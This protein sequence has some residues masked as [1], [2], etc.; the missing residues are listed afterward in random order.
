MGETKIFSMNCQGL[1]NYR[2]RK[3]VL[4]YIRAR[5]Y[6]IIC[7][8]DIHVDKNTAQLMLNEWGYGGI[9]APHTTAAR[10]VAVMF[11]NNLEY[12]IHQSKLDPRGNFIV[13]SLQ[14]ENEML[15]LINLYGPNNDTPDFYSSLFA[16]IDFDSPVIICGDWNL[17]LDPKIDTQN[18]IRVN[19]P[20]AREKVLQIIEENNLCDPWR[21]QH[22]ETKGFTWRKKTP[23]KQA[24]LDFFLTTEDMMSYITD[25]KIMP[26][27]KT[28]HSAILITLKFSNGDRGK[29]Y[30]KFNNSFLK[31]T[32]FADNV[33]KTINSVLSQYAATPYKRETIETLPREE[34][35]FQIK[36]QLLLDVMLMEIRQQSIEYGAKKKKER[37]K[38]EK[39][40]ENNIA[41]AEEELNSDV[42]DATD[43]L[44]EKLENFKAELYQIRE[45]KL[46]GLI[47]RSKARWYNEGEKPTK[48]FCGLE[49]RNYTAKVIRELEI[50][51]KRITSQADIIN[52]QKTF[53]EKL[54]DEHNTDTERAKKVMTDMN[55]KKITPIQA[56][57]IEGQISYDELCQ[58]VRQMKNNKSPG[59]DGYSVEFFKFFWQDLGKLILRAINEAYTEGKFSITQRR[60]VITCLPKPNKDRRYL[61]NWRPITL[62]TVI[63]KM[64]S[65]CIANRLRQVLDTII[66]DDQSGFMKG[67]FI[68]DNIRVLYDIL[69]ETKI[70]NIPGLMISIDFEKAFDS[71]SSQFI[72]QAL[73]IFGFG[74][75]IQK[76]V[77]TLNNDITGCIIQNGFL[78]RSFPI[79]RGCRQG[80]PAAPYIFLISIQI[81]IDMIKNNASIRGIRLN[82]IEHKLSF[83]ADDG[84]IY[85][86]GEEASLR[87][88]MNT[89]N[90]F[91]QMSG[92]KVNTKKT[93]AIWIGKMRKN[94]D[95]I[96]RDL[97]L[98]WAEDSFTVLG[99]KFNAEL[100][101][102]TE[103]NLEEKINKIKCLLTQWKRRK[104]SLLG[105]ITVIKTLAVSQITHILT[106]LP[107]PTEY[108]MKEI[109]KL[110]YKFL[111]NNGPDKIKRNIIIQNYDKGG[112]KMIDIQSF[113]QH[114]K[115]TWIKRAITADHKWCT[116]S[117]S[118]LNTHDFLRFGANYM[119]CTKATRNPF[120]LDVFRAWETLTESNIIITMSAEELL[121][122]PIWYNTHFKNKHLCIQNWAKRGIIFIKDL[123]DENG[124][125]WKFEILKKQYDI[126][127]TILDYEQVKH[128]IPDIW[129]RKLRNT[130]NTTMMPAVPKHIKQIK[131]KNKKAA[132]NSIIER[133]INTQHSSMK[134]WDNVIH[135]EINWTQVY[136]NAITATQSTYL[137][138]FHYKAIYNVICTNI[139]LF[140]MKV[141]EDDTCSFCHK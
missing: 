67:R 113:V 126:R 69:Y 139:T 90:T 57:E 110:F 18:Y 81:L 74:E 72:Q 136:K 65:G 62:L 96:C 118:K 15:T 99:V 80:D 27:Y 45:E 37:N 133:K 48:Y 109:Q 10:G 82:S 25:S 105:K 6:N 70:Q 4:N 100:E 104:L 141:K 66:S 75:S 111:W 20:R 59:Q 39:E 85:L 130:G 79:K 19:N 86:D 125:F 40:L 47:T 5:D 121:S 129:T 56:R 89:L 84:L 122:E 98:T 21:V 140:R 34:I 17:A 114:L 108:T 119:K 31:D 58:T 124:N 115:L 76:W 73:Q 41:L 123:L 87:A 91:Y 83:Y 52:E 68:G 44:F 9:I 101:N 132:Y 53:Y 11:S 116:L 102:I 134:K 131:S 8:Q 135:E 28:D 3:D 107:N 30:W 78:S 138:S 35:H 117:F 24:R 42:S 38:K 127:G 103:I 54:Y 12:K 94:T 88:L 49:K 1:A 71:I 43:D 50:D 61:S 60:G 92:L 95:P 26:G 2:N 55:I 29:G 23:R 36:D 137:R 32:T 33:R 93:K 97:G 7:L 106:A 77:K 128:N 16:D 22:P 112:L 64:A 51:G 14:I 13:L 63:Y 120:W 46:N